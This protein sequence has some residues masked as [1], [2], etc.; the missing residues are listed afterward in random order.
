VGSK[1]VCRICGDVDLLSRTQIE[2]AN[3]QLRKHNPKAN[4]DIVDL[5]NLPSS[6]ESKSVPNSPAR[7]AMLM[8]HLLN[9]KY[10]A[11][12][13]SASALPVKLHE[14]LTVGAITNRLTPYDVLIS[15]EEQILDELPLNAR[16]V[17]N[18]VRREAQMLYYRPDLKM[19]RA[20]GSIDA[21][22][23]K[24]NSAKIDAVV[25]SAADVE[26]LHK[27]DCVVEVFTNSVCIPAAG[28]GSLAILVRCEDDRTK[29]IVAS[30]NDPASFSEIK[31]EWSFLEHIGLSESDPVG[32]LGNIEG[33]KLELEGVVALPDGREKI[34]SALKGSPGREQELGQQLANEI[35]EAGGVE[36][37]QELNLI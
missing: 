36:I 25:L 28:Q 18:E 2:E 14:G 20:K 37:L 7:V 30:V 31:A 19:V 4:I 16:I 35:M 12:V 23:Q 32:V 10:D 11:L 3:N 1:S 13:L 24:V 6:A 22:I 27:Q 5:G 8:K 21:L 26:W 33:D 29:K 34:C 17:A 9:E 15:H